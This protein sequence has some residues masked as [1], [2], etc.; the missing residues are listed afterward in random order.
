MI[1]WAVMAVDGLDGMAVD[2]EEVA[3][4]DQAQVGVAGDLLGA[5]AG[6]LGEL[7]LGPTFGSRQAMRRNR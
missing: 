7:A 4:S 6:A 1:V 2:E 5:V 3:G